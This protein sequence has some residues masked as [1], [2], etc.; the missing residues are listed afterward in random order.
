MVGRGASCDIRSDDSALADRLRASVSGQA[1]ERG[2]DFKETAVV[3]AKHHHNTFRSFE[4]RHQAHGS[5][6]LA[7]LAGYRPTPGQT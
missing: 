5:F 4:W 2:I 3:G 7:S 6:L 1:F